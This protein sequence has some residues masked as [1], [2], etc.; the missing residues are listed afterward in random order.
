M[1]T[2]SASGQS[3]QKIIERY[4]QILVKQPK[5]G[6]AFDRVFEYHRANESI[7][8]WLNTLADSQEKSWKHALLRGMVQSRLGSF[9]PAISA[10]QTAE[11]LTDKNETASMALPALYLAQAY[12]SSGKAES[13]IGAYKKALELATQ[14][15]QRLEIATALTELLSLQR[16]EAEALE[17]WNA[18]EVYF[19]SDPTVLEIIATKLQDNGQLKD[20]KQRFL[21]VERLAPTMQKK[22]DAAFRVA[23]IEL[24]LGETES[25]LT[26]LQD[27]AKRV[28][29][30]SWLGERVRSTIETAYID[31]RDF[32][33]LDAYF[34]N[35]I[36]KN[37]GD[38]AATIRYAE[39]LRNQG[40]MDEATDL[41]RE[42][43]KRLPSNQNIVQAL[44]SFYDA[45][46]EPDRALL[47]LQ[48]LVE[49]D[50]KNPDYLQR[51][52]LF[53]AANTE[54]SRDERIQ[55]AETIWRRMVRNERD[56][57]GLLRVADLVRKFDA[58]QRVAALAREA[59]ESAP[60]DP[61]PRFYLA[62]TLFQS[63]RNEEA[64]QVLREIESLDI[65]EFD[66]LQQLGEIYNDQGYIE[67][68]I[69]VM[70]IACDRSDNTQARIRLA[71][72]LTDAD[73]FTDAIEQLR[74]A[75]ASAANIRDKCSVW[76]Q[77][78][79]TCNSAKSIR[80]EILL[81]KQR[82]RSL[83]SLAASSTSDKEAKEPLAEAHCKLAILQLASGNDSE[84]AFAMTMAVKADP[85]E[86]FYL[87]LA[88][89]YQERAGQLGNAVDLYEELAKRDRSARSST[90]RRIA[91]LQMQ[92]GFRDASLTTA[93]QLLDSDASSVEDYRYVADLC[94][95]SG[96][97][98]RGIRVLK[99]CAEIHRTDPSSLVALVD[100]FSQSYQ[101]KEAIEYAWRLFDLA[102]RQ[103]HLASE[104]QI[105]AVSTLTE[106][107]LRFESFSALL[108]KI[109][110]QLAF[111]GTPEQRILLV[112]VA[113]EVAG[114]KYAALKRLKALD[115]GER[116]QPFILKRLRDLALEEDLG[117][118]ANQYAIRLR[119]SRSGGD[120]LNNSG[121]SNTEFGRSPLLGNQG[122][123][124]ASDW[125][126]ETIESVDRS[127]RQLDFA[128]AQETLDSALAAEPQSWELLAFRAY[129]ERV[130]AGPKQE[131]MSKAILAIDLPY[132][133]RTNRIAPT[134]FLRSGNAK[135]VG[136]VQP[137]KTTSTSLTRR[138]W[139]ERSANMQG[140]I[141]SSA[142]AVKILQTS[143]GRHPIYSQNAP[144]IAL[145]ELIYFGDAITIATT[146]SYAGAASLS[147]VSQ[148][149][150]EE[151]RAAL[152]QEAIRYQSLAMYNV[153][154]N[155][156]QPLTFPNQQFADASSA[157]G[158]EAADKVTKLSRQSDR[159]SPTTQAEIQKSV[160]HFRNS[161]FFLKCLSNLGDQDA[162]RALLEMDF[163]SRFQ[164]NNKGSVISV[165]LSQ[166]HLDT[167]IEL[168]A[169]DAELKK[170]PRKLIWLIEETRRT[171]SDSS[172][173]RKLIQNCDASP[174][175][176][177]AT[178]MQSTQIDSKELC[179]NRALEWI[180]SR[181]SS[182]SEL[183]PSA[184]P[185]M[186]TLMQ[187][188]PV[189][190]WGP[191]YADGRADSATEDNEPSMATAIGTGSKSPASLMERLIRAQI[192]F[193]QNCS[194]DDLEYVDLT[195]LTSKLFSIP[196]SKTQ[197]PN[198]VRQSALFT[199]SA[200]LVP[201]RTS[202]LQTQYVRGPTSSLLVPV[203]LSALL[204]A[205]RFQT[206]RHSISRLEEIMSNLESEYARSESTREGK[207]DASQRSQAFIQLLR[208]YQL[209][210][211]KERD[212]AIQEVKKICNDSVLG[213]TPR[214]VLAQMQ[215]DH[216][217]F[218]S[219]LETIN[220]LNAYTSKS[221]LA[222]EKKRL[223]LGSLLN[224]RKIAADA[225]TK[226]FSM[227]LD[228]VTKSQVLETLEAMKITSLA[229][230]LARRSGSTTPEQKE[231]LLK[232]MQRSAASDDDAKAIL[233]AK[234]I[235]R[236]TNSQSNI[237]QLLSTTVDGSVLIANQR[238]F[239]LSNGQI[240]Q[241]AGGV[242]DRQVA[243]KTLKRL[244]AL[245]PLIAETKQILEHNP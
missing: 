180:E 111:R 140:S 50:P 202:Q 157:Y 57:S 38:S 4:E 168:T 151:D 169:S 228:R 97:E 116:T 236:Q 167:L 40:K 226:L 207:D 21:S 101:G 36:F 135:L 121:F 52:G 59:I 177:V 31:E 23:E 128:T 175:Q 26:R 25:A 223:E 70:S 58:P 218:G 237:V 224:D 60:K 17:V 118:Q 14:K 209:W 147:E 230:A 241:R 56:S 37:P 155:G 6:T 160:Q 44:A 109:E 41:L 243:F 102:M 222:L 142:M 65:P 82:L 78:G 85:S 162:T 18:L 242:S 96:D 178:A 20:A 95:R 19:Q 98:A 83:P 217:L 27:L 219:A 211:N 77:L 165:A 143:N 106:T 55:E 139:L 32:L 133:T 15:S 176:W 30:E 164:A 35:W 104:S 193:V 186:L 90:Y 187:A 61:S 189:L 203:Q 145:P 146:G 5:Y 232:R 75:E 110:N 182:L 22:V 195:Q 205:T 43:R 80:A 154:L 88:A 122:S 68:C 181:K 234:T 124:Q 129:V 69:R 120:I 86:R 94:F 229:T 137:Q 10:F 204:S 210:D 117:E 39:L 227:R 138:E 184:N 153:R 188:D 198:R 158:H 34:R 115:V 9:E 201:R 174:T 166:Q 152:W 72:I 3:E 216:Q 28:N 42:T 215:T 197:S 119:N 53:T 7:E 127:L 76:G 1:F 8:T 141:F 244:G 225:A 63:E 173:I 126:T 73:F 74:L 93:E 239:R 16:R 45:A 190:F 89:E 47:M 131:E 148:W 220:D 81:T 213:Q 105:D 149:I 150:A 170:D 79:D 231:S 233:Y 51:L 199:P 46:G 235:L 130:V 185:V 71:K 172:K 159:E 240:Y 99:R 11:K 245:T 29:S 92:L 13:A 200:L 238:Y 156:S 12:E 208:C 113:Y 33:G 48:E 107:Y 191:E 108:Q 91:D 194:D 171:Q 212:Q 62:N 214:V 2:G 132:D 49:L 192:A 67:D 136:G 112:S 206:N 134:S 100:R 66:H 163:L 54:G 114:F 179:L 123:G 64:F 87:E 24:E 144:K 161:T 103:N 221:I 196:T 183:G 84:A 125:M